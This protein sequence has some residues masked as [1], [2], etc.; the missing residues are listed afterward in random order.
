MAGGNKSFVRGTED[1]AEFRLAVD[2][3]ANLV[4]FNINSLG[5]LRLV[6]ERVDLLHYILTDHVEAFVVRVVTATH[7]NCVEISG[8]DLLFNDE[9]LI[10]KPL[11]RIK[12]GM[13]THRTVTKECFQSVARNGTDTIP[14]VMVF[15]VKILHNLDKLGGNGVT[16]ETSLNAFRWTDWRVR[17]VSACFQCFAELGLHGDFCFGLPKRK[18]KLVVYE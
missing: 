9:A 13:G 4:E 8:P 5:V 15:F 12:I 3:N 10:D 6:N 14:F 1:V 7:R 16:M 17:L 2:S 11:K 18:K